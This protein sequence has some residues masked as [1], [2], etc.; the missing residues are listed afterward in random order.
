[1]TIKF[2]FFLSPSSQRDLPA[3]TMQKPQGA[4]VMSSQALPAT[5]DAGAEPP[6]P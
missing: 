6:K 5:R 3:T 1:M 4:A 2:F